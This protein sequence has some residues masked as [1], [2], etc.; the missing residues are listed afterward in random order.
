MAT[1]KQFVDYKISDLWKKFL[2]LVEDMTYEHDENFTKLANALP[3]HVNLIN[4]ANWLTE[5]KSRFLRKRILDMGNDTLRSLE[6]VL[7]ATDAEIILKVKGNETK[8]SIH[9]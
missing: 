3:E 5:E 7:S 4:Q 1:V 2:C 8:N 6:S 9:V